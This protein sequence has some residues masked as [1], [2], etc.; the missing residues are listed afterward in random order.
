MVRSCRIREKKS[1][2]QFRRILTDFPLLVSILVTFLFPYAVVA[3]LA[4]V[5]LN[6]SGKYIYPLHVWVSNDQ[7]QNRKMLDSFGEARVKKYNP[8]GN[9]SVSSPARMEY[10]SC[11]SRAWAIIISYTRE[12]N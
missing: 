6:H 11:V 2:A 7:I 12:H 9:G 5:I 1:C 8:K 3:I 4:N 10:V